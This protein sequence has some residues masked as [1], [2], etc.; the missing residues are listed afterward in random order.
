MLRPA[1]VPL[2]SVG[3]GVRV[4]YQALHALNLRLE[5]VELQAHGRLVVH[6]VV[7]QLVAAGDDL[8][9]DLLAAADLAADD[10]H[11]RVGVVIVQDLEDL[12]GVLGGRVVD[13]QGDDLAAARGARSQ[14]GGE[15]PERDFPQDVGPPALEV[16][17]QKD[18]RAVEDVEGEEEQE[19]QG[20]EQEEG[21]H[22]VAAG[23]AFHLGGQPEEG[24]EA[25][26]IIN[27]VCSSSSSGQGPA[28]SSFGSVASVF[29]GC[30]LVW[31]CLGG[32][33]VPGSSGSIFG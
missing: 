27:S 22:P 28:G 2:A 14:V 23:A 1:A 31:S 30:L 15:V 21:G 25:D 29:V 13:G 8:A 12:A 32:G 20:E 33:S 17:D 18:G 3:V 11:G 5:L 16:A 10:E 24:G 6:G 26:H 7:A 4:P 9:E 19:E